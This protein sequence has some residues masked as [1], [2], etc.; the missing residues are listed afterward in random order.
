MKNLTFLLFLCTFTLTAQDTFSIVAVDPETG[1]VGAAGA[2]CIDTDDC[3]G[4]GGVIIIN[5][6]IP[7]RGGMN[8]QAYAC[9][10]NVNL[11]NGIAQMIDGASP[12]AALDFV[13]AND[14]CFSGGVSNQ[15]SAYR[16]Y[17]FADLDENN[18]P[19]SAAYT[20]SSTDA[21]AGH[22]TGDNYAIQGN[23]LLGEQILTDMETGFLNAEGTLAEKLMA[24]LQGANVPG[25]DTRC[26]AAGISSK[27]AFIRVA[28]PEDTDGNFWLEINVPAVAAGVEPIDELQGLFDA[29]L[30]TVGTEVVD[31]QANVS[32]FPNPVTDSFSLT[33]APSLFVAGMKLTIY[34]PAGKVILTEKMT[35]ARRDFA[36]GELETKGIIFIEIKDAKGETVAAEKVILR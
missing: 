9:L 1:E 25:A 5:D 29:W 18:E 34:D 35:A 26:L 36:A 27:S 14:A 19:R 11:Q 4:C 20:G 12:Q 24:A 31:N 13:T 23:I 32:V 33:V 22:I 30:A 17:G 8:S 2:S 6:L 28:K 10:P 21:Y 15:N 7:G 16:Q 3:G